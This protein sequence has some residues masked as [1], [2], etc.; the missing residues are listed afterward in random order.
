[1]R[2]HLIRNWLFGKEAFVDDDAEKILNKKNWSPEQ[3]LSKIFGLYRNYFETESNG[4]TR[5]D[6][7]LNWVKINVLEGEKYRYTVIKDGKSVVDNQLYA[8]VFQE[9][10]QKMFMENYR[11]LVYCTS[12]ITSDEKFDIDKLSDGDQRFLKHLVVTEDRFKD[13]Q[14]DYMNFLMEVNLFNKQ[15]D[16]QN[17]KAEMGE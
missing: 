5:E 4:K 9:T 2:K 14:V 7:F 8:K 17:A 6:G 11:N 3:K 12:K 15:N 1:M 13:K 16:E 10:A